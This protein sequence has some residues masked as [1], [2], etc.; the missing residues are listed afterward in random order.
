MSP[1]KR[2]AIA[3]VAC[4][5]IG[6]HVKTIIPNKSPSKA[7]IIVAHIRFKF[8]IQIN[9]QSHNVTCR[10]LEIESGRRNSDKA[11]SVIMFKYPPKVS[12]SIVSSQIQKLTDNSKWT[13]VI[14]SVSVCNKKGKSKHYMIVIILICNATSHIKITTD[15]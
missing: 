2:K 8:K 3:L 12:W 7:N 15:T 9:I 4:R 13:M 6:L 11:N 14:L 10:M 1:N 5:E